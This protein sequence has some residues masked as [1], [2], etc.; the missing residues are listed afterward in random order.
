[1]RANFQPPGFFKILL[2]KW[3]VQRFRDPI[4]KLAYL[5]RAAKPRTPRR[6]LG[7]HWCLKMTLLLLVFLGS[8]VETV[9]DLNASLPREKRVAKTSSPQKNPAALGVTWLVEQRGDYEVY[10]NGLRIENRFLTPNVPRA[11]VIFPHGL[12]PGTHTE[13]RTKPAGII[14][15]TS[16]GV[17]APFTP[18]QNEILTRIGQELLRFV[19]RHRAYH[20]VIDR[21][22][23]VFRVVPETD[24]ANH[25][26]YSVW[27]DADGVYVNLNHSFLGISFE[28]QTRG[29]EHGYYLSSAQIHSGRLLVEM[30]VGKYKIP[31]TNCVTHAQ[32]SIDPE[33]MVMGN[34]TDGSGNFPFYELGIPDNHLLPIPSLYVFGF[35]FDSRY[36]LL[37]GSHM[38]KGLLLAHERLLQDANAQ[39]LPVGQYKKIL[40]ERYR[41]S[42]AT[43]MDLGVIKETE[44]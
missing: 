18:S 38:W 40:Q 33:T 16:E 15:H 4:Q 6:R 14:F 25:A 24:V 27:A 44:R 28:A 11:Y 37:T 9:S 41:T 26:G 20:F 23:R 17:Q 13:L 19:S 7:A 10:S 31:L 30:L 34:H 43:L 32:V 29:V 8:K 21:F 39:H 35:E 22:G 3:R 12:P 2:I 1:M 5:R 42:I 36:L